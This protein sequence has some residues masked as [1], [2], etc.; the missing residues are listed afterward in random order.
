MTPV[1]KRAFGGAGD[2]GIYMRAQISGFWD[3]FFV[4]TPS[5]KALQNF[6]RELIV[7]KTVIHGP[8]QFCYFAP[9][10]DLYVDNMISP[11][12]F[13]NQFMD[14]FRSIAYVLEFCGIFFSCFLLIEL[15]VDL[16]VLI[17]RQ[18]EFNRLTV[19]SLGFGKTVLSA[20]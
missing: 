1:S 13:K 4:S 11:D 8:E 10:T 19:A 3:N 17:S 12:F 16:I 18:L 2:A 5:R 20:Y 9:R 15:I 7:P 14:T 6:S